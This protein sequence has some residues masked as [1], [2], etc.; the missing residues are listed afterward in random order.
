MSQ[1][2]I[3]TGPRDGELIDHWSTILEIPVWETMLV[4]RF[5]HPDVMEPMKVEKLT[6]VRHRFGVAQEFARPVE[7]F[8][9][10]EWSL[11]D[12]NNK[13]IAWLI[14]RAFKG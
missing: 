13:I 6:F 12:R 11:F 4:Q 1:A 9:P 10:I 2:R 7:F 3:V 8:V 14:R 5:G